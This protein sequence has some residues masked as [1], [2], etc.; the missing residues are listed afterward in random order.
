M[1]H[2]AAVHL[3]RGASQRS[4]PATVRCSGTESLQQQLPPTMATPSTLADRLAATE[5]SKSTGVYRFATLKYNKLKPKKPRTVVIDTK[6]VQLYVIATC[7]LC[8]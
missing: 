2:L 6:K 4:R 8:Y 7:W 5:A 1:H 3:V